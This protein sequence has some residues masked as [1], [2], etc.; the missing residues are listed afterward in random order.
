MMTLSS[1]LAQPRHGYLDRIKHIVGFLSRMNNPVICIRTDMPDFSDVAIERYD[2]SKTVYAD[3][4]EE[5]S[6]NIS[7]PKGQP[8]KVTTSADSKLCRTTY[9]MG[10]QFQ[11][12]SILSIR[13]HLIGTL[14]N[15]QPQRLPHME[16]VIILAC[17]CIRG[18][19]ING[20][21]TSKE[22]L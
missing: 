1:F 5:V 2:L 20:D 13:I 10:R 12:L 18:I 3:A 9:L 17:A 19:T 21:V 16:H 15:R 14:R 6:H 4:D 8:V 22:G 11:G 7:Q